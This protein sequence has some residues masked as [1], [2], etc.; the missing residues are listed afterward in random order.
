MSRMWKQ[1]SIGESQADLESGNE[2]K[3]TNRAC[4]VPL[5]KGWC[6]DSVD[7]AAMLKMVEPGGIPEQW[8]VMAQADRYEE[9]STTC[10]YSISWCF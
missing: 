5:A 4:F 8:Q 7:G 10:Q 1:R 9:I 3:V 2:G 6:M